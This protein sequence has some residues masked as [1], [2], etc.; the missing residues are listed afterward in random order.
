MGIRYLPLT[1]HEHRRFGSRERVLDVARRYPDRLTIILNALASR[2]IL[3]HDRATGV[4]YLEGERLYRA[5]AR[6]SNDAG[7]PRTIMASREVILSGGAF[8]TPKLLMLSGI[9][10]PETLERHGIPV[11]VPLAGVGKNLQDRY[12]VGVVNRMKSASWTVYDG[13]TF[14][15]TDPQFAEWEN[16]GRG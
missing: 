5:H 1:T 2:V 6:P 9:G 16:G 7:R 10:P 11:R 8:N 12:E 13:A 3:E 15:K 14:S 4:E